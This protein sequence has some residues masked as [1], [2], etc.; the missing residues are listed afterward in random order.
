MEKTV[1]K[2][3]ANLGP[4]STKDQVNGVS[5]LF[6][7]WAGIGERWSQTSKTVIFMLLAAGPFLSAAL[8]YVLRRK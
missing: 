7:A 1:K 6:F 8:A 4:G 5:H 2:G 3:I